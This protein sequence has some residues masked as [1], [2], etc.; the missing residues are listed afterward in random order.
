MLFKELIFN[1]YFILTFWIFLCIILFFS[2][3]QYSLLDLLTKV[4]ASETELLEALKKIE[5][6]EIDGGLHCLPIDRSDQLILI[7]SKI[8]QRA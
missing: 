4:Q 3:L 1:I 8:A 2:I 6:L 7:K 5:A